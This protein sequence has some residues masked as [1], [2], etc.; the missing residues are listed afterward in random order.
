MS[1]ALEPLLSLEKCVPEPP[2]TRRQTRTALLLAC[3]ASLL[4]Y[5]ALSG[6]MAA[7][8]K[9]VK[10]KPLQMA[11]EIAFAPVVWIATHRVEP[12]SSWL[13]AYVELF[14]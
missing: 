7:L 13:R 14:R 4:L 8:H 2:R 11:I 6:P 1:E 9:S 3:G 12:V 10:F 5:V